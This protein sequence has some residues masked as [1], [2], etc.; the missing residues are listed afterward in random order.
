MIAATQ[1]LV[2]WLQANGIDPKTV[3]LQLECADLVTAER[4][5]VTLSRDFEAGRTLVASEHRP[6]PVDPMTISGMAVSIVC[7]PLNAEKA[8]PLPQM[9]RWPS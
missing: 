9:E 3:K 7:P 5:F 1:A 2:A 8:P 6:G 4:I